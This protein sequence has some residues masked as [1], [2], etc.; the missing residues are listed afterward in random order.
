MRATEHGTRGSA[1]FSLVELVVVLVIL[2]LMATIVA[3]NWR[4]IL[5][6]TELH[7]AVRDLAATLQTAR[8]EAIS[9]NSVYHVQYDL[10]ASRWRIVTPFREGGTLALV[11]EERIAPPWK[12]MPGSVRFQSITVDGIEFQSDGFAELAECPV[13]SP[14]EWAREVSDS[15]DLATDVADGDEYSEAYERAVDYPALVQ[16]FVTSDVSDGLGP[17]SF[18]VSVSDLPSGSYRSFLT[19]EA[20]GEDVDVSVD[21]QTRQGVDGLDGDVFGYCYRGE[22]VSG[23]GADFVDRENGVALSV[24]V[25]GI[26]RT[27]DEAVVALEEVLDDMVEALLEGARTN[28][29]PVTIPGADL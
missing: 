29:T 14:A 16:C 17:T 20:Y 18:G 24:Y 12:P 15:I 22:E 5:P 25:Q 9:R 7:S 21:I 2:A 27:A 6:K 13:G 23:C 19:F 28:R 1:G 3:V 8:S 26:D 4:A 10:D 11:E